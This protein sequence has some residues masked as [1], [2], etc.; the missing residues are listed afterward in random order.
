MHSINKEAIKTD[1]RPATEKDWL[2]ISVLLATVFDSPY[3]ARLVEK[4]RRDGDMAMELVAV[5]DGGCYA[6]IAFAKMLAPQG[7]WS[8]SPVAVQQARQGNGVGSEVIR[9]SLDEARQADANAV[10]VLGDP[11]YY[12]RFG[13]SLQAA[14]NLMTPF[15]QKLTM[16]YPIAPGTGGMRAAVSYPAAFFQD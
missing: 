13:F 4:L 3:E 15:A 16:L 1:L 12:G 2:S 5:D 6:Y 11:D 8:L 7:V 14:Q 9:Q 10:I